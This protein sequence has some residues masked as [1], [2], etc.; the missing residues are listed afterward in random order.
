MLPPPLM[1]AEDLRAFAHRD[2][3]LLAESKAQMWRD[4]SGITPSQRLRVADQLH[5]FARHTHPDWL[6]ELD[7]AEDLAMHQRLAELLSRARI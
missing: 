5:L 6:T 3:A 2:W 4:E 1:N 7:R